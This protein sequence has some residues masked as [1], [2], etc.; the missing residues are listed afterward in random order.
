[1]ELVVILILI[2]VLTLAG[3]I[4]LYFLIRSKKNE[5]L[6]CLSAAESILKEEYLEEVLQNDRQLD[7]SE[8]S[9][10]K[11]VYIKSCG[12]PKTKVVF[13]PKKRILFGRGSQCN[14]YIN[15]NTVSEKHCVI[16]TQGSLVYL[17]GCSSKNGTFLTRG[18]SKFYITGTERVCLNT[19]D[20]L[21]V[22]DQKF[23]VYLFNYCK[24]RYCEDM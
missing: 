17:Q 3:I 23:K 7:C 24:K 6:K 20:I 2:T 13:D 10:K 21:K 9:N 5:R 16:Y 19:K 22:G 15:D 18:F 14:I 12:K 11:M 1:M 4:M 8:M